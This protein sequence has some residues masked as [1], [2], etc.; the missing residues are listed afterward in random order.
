MSLIASDAGSL[1]IGGQK[2]KKTYLEYE[3]IIEEQAL[4]WLG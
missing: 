4:F 2:K 1:F 3:K